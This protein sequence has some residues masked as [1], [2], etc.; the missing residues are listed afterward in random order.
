[1]LFWRVAVAK[2]YQKG[3]LGENALKPGGKKR[4]LGRS[5]LC[6]IGLLLKDGPVL[7]WSSI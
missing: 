2:S 7:Y 3:E 5:N 6:L 1:M 4:L